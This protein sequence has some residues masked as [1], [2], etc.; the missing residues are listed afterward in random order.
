MNCVYYGS[1]FNLQFSE[2]KI[3][4]CF[5]NFPLSTLKLIRLVLSSSNNQV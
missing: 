4:S 1:Q 3:F 2:G 5:W